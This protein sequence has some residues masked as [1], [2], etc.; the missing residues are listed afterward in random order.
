MARSHFI[1]VRVNEREHSLIS[2]LAHRKGISLSEWI[3]TAALRIAEQ[4]EVYWQNNR[5]PRGHGQLDING[6]CK[7]CDA[8]GTA[9]SST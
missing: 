7:E 2:S 6:V 9:N 5:C 4:E 3:R 1:N 8:N